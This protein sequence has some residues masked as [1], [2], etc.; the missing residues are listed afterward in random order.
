MRKTEETLCETICRVLN[1]GC[2]IS[3]Q[4]TY[5]AASKKFEVRVRDYSKANRDG[6]APNGGLVICEICSE[7][8]LKDAIEYAYQLAHS[9]GTL[10]VKS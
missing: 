9:Q 6:R 8:E 5:P 10:N 4:T 1:D 7:D 2:D 3:L